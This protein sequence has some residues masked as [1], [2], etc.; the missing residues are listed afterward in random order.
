ME[1]EASEVMKVA[2]NMARAK[3]RST[4]RLPTSVADSDAPYASYYEQTWSWAA[5][6]GQLPSE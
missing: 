2:T 6:R 4:K 5:L 1:H 3:K